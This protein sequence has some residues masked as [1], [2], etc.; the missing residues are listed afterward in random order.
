MSGVDLRALEVFGEWSTTEKAVVQ[1]PGGAFEA[2]VDRPSACYAVRTRRQ[3]E[4]NKPRANLE[5]DCAPVMTTRRKKHRFTVI[6]GLGKVNR[7]HPPPRRGIGGHLVPLAPLDGSTGT[8]YR[9]KQHR[10]LVWT[11]PS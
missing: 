7:I 4:A 3:K 9:T 6:G 2:V 5:P 11:R 1:A 10:K 8:P